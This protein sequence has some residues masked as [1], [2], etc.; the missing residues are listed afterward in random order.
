MRIGEADG[1]HS[2]GASTPCILMYFTADGLGGLS[3]PKYF[4]SALGW[5]KGEGNRMMAITTTTKSR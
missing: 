1:S 5:T 4:S 3:Q 2:H